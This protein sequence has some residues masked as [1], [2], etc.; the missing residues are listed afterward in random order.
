MNKVAFDPRTWV[1][2]MPVLLIGAQVRGKANF[3]P[4]GWTGIANG[5]PPMLSVALR[6]HRYTY[7]G[8]RE[9]MIFSV[10]LP[11]AE[12][13][14]A[15]DLCGHKS[16]FEG[17]KV[18]QCGFSVFYGRLG[19]AP[20][21]EQCP[22]NMECKVVHMLGLDSHAFIVGRKEAVYVSEDCLSDGRP[23]VEKMRPLAY[24]ETPV[25][26]YRAIGPMI[27]AQGFSTHNPDLG[28]GS[29]A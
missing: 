5:E 23:D 3:M 8:I 11:S 12:M 7:T 20:L 17:D 6:Y 18:K 4:V 26:H 10:N 2:P 9:N 1:Y 25:R 13:L 28:T 21:I 16:G 27:A 14:K 15:I 19:S 29:D 22:L 24:V